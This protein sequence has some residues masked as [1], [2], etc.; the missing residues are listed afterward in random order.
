MN[1]LMPWGSKARVRGNFFSR[2]HATP[3]LGNVITPTFG[4]TMYL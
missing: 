4:R 1:N 3:A 2:R